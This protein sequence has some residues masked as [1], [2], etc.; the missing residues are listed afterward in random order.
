MMPEEWRQIITLQPIVVSRIT[1]L[2]FQPLE[3]RQSN[4]FFAT[5]RQKKLFGSWEPWWHEFSIPLGD[6]VPFSSEV[7]PLPR[8]LTDFV[9]FQVGEAL[10]CTDALARPS[11]R[12]W[13][14][15]TQSTLPTLEGLR[16]GRQ[17]SSAFDLYNRKFPWDRGAPGAWL[18]FRINEMGRHN[19]NKY[20]Q[21][22]IGV[23]LAVGKNFFAKGLRVL[24]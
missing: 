9:L 14:L 5:L 23:W 20:Y 19:Q 13:L 12:H 15:C 6:T 4:S 10:L 11:Q 3:V 21:P 16:S 2:L 1:T 22:P 24:E 18:P 8:A 17:A 7:L